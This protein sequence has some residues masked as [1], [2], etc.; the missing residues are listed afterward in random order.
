M[1]RRQ[2][3]WLPPKIFSFGYSGGVNF[4][5]FEEAAGRASLSPDGPGRSFY[6]GLS[7]PFSSADIMG[8]QQFLA[9]P[10]NRQR[11]TPAALVY[12]SHTRCGCGSTSSADCV[13][14]GQCAQAGWGSYAFLLEE[15][16]KC[17][18]YRT[19]R[20]VQTRPNFLIAE[21]LKHTLQHLTLTLRKGF[22]P[23][24]LFRVF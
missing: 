9:R 18:L 3:T 13:P 19:L 6:I 5:D 7:V 11:P 17:S 21:S 4:D 8:F 22:G 15:L 16:L 12:R 1:E 20:D 2:R 23:V 14:R 10:R 24:P